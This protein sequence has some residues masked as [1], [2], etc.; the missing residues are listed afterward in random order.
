MRIEPLTKDTLKEAID[1]IIRVFDSEPKD[2]DYPGKWLTLSL[3]NEMNERVDA[4]AV[5]TYCKYYV[6]IDEETGK[7]IGTT[8]IYSL[9]VD[10]E[11]SDWIAWYCVDKKYRGKG[12]GS[13]LLDY[14]I[15]LA[16]E[17]GKIYLKLYTSHNTD[18]KDAMVLYNKRGFKIVKTEKH[19]QTGE[20]MIY[21][22]MDLN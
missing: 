7:V 16:K 6:G 19:P 21:M 4:D 13:K 15:N 11:D 2:Q 5:C 22:Q 18:I 10:E 14:A 1:L 3:N 20:E 17:R 8:G 9:D 12:Y